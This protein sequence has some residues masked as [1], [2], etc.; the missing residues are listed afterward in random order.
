MLLSYRLIA[1]IYGEKLEG[2]G[3]IDKR[4]AMMVVSEANFDLRFEFSN[5]NYPGLYVYIAVLEAA[6]AMVASK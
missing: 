2:N 1:L 5:L 4:A 6:E 3:P